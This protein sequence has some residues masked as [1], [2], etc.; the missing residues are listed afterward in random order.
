MKD[1]FDREIKVEENLIHTITHK[2]E[3]TKDDFIF[4]TI[5]SFMGTDIEMSKIPMSKQILCRALICF[6]REHADE[7]FRLLDE[8][9]T[10]MEQAKE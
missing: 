3:E 4:T 8:S 5:S 7:Y 6:Q 10:R 9:N 2:V 1:L